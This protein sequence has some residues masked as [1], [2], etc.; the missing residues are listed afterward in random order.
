MVSFFQSCIV[1]VSLSS[2]SAL[3]PPVVKTPGKTIGG[4]SSAG[5]GLGAT[6]IAFAVSGGNTIGFGVAF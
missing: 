6:G 4:G 2:S 5:A 1:F 3:R